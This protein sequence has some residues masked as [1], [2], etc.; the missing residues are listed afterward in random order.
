[1]NCNLYNPIQ[2]VF[3]NAVSLL[4]IFQLEAVGDE[5]RGVAENTALS[6]F[7]IPPANFCCKG[8]ILRGIIVKRSGDIMQLTAT[9]EL[10]AAK[11]LYRTAFPKE[12][13][14]PWWVL[15]LSTLE[16]GVEL[17]AYYDEGEFCG[18][19][20]TTVT[21][22]VLFVMFLAVDDTVR[23]VGYGSAIL[24]HLKS[25]AQGRPVILNVEPLDD[26][27]PN[28]DERVRRMRFYEKNGFYD[29][30]YNIAEVGGIFRVLSTV[31]ELNVPAYLKVFAKLS[32][33]LWKP[34]ITKVR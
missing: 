13:R 25:K 18:F 19:T 8:A 30:G 28:A 16:Q 29:T 21:E 20:H 6:A 9:K 1:M 15:R 22:D 3:K 34:E 5:G 27:A 7:I 4:D 24:E 2:F 12:E 17:A 26:A 33:G 11:R 32:F 14:L 10:V 23:G 31:P